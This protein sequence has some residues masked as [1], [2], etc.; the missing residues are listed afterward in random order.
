MINLY[1]LIL[2]VSSTCCISMSSKFAYLLQRKNYNGKKALCLGTSAAY[3][4][5]EISNFVM[6]LLIQG[7]YYNFIQQMLNLVF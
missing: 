2:I 5:S 1:Q 6:F 7:E 3:I 4:I